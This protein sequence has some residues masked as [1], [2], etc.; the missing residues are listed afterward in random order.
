MQDQHPVEMRGRLQSLTISLSIGACGVHGFVTA[1]LA[2]DG[3]TDA[4]GRSAS[5]LYEKDASSLMNMLIEV[6]TT[7]GVEVALLDS[8]GMYAGSSD[9]S[10]G[11]QGCEELDEAF[12]MRKM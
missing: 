4:V 2:L 5:S 12:I 8:S 1:E 7:Y 9:E 10:E 3:I 6:K 11:S